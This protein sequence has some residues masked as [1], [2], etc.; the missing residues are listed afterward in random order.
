MESKRKFSYDLTLSSVDYEL[1]IFL[2][3]IKTTYPDDKSIFF[4]IGDHGDGWNE[5]RNSNLRKDFGFR[6]Y[7]ENINI[8]FIISPFKE[9]KNK[10]NTLFD[11][12]SV[13]ATILKI[14]GIAS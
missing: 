14:M 4:I 6:T 5:K 12:M 9:Y 10:V 8:P 1:S 7:S 2:K 3:R 11:S 13:S